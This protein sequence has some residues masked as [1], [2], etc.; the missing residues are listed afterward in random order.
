MRK[1]TVKI[2][3]KQLP[4]NS[5]IKKLCHHSLC[6][7]LFNSL[8]SV[9]TELYQSI[10]HSFWAQPTFMLI[11]FQ[12]ANFRNNDLLSSL[13][14]CICGQILED[15]YRF[16]SVCF[17]RRKVKSNHQWMP[18]VFTDIESLT[19]RWVLN[20]TLTKTTYLHCFANLLIKLLTRFEYCVSF[21]C[22]QLVAMLQ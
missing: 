22:N 10:V 16:Y 12:K 7:S 11:G 19:D 14:K 4:M 6:A 2:S 17:V 5:L 18:F 3:V 9:C 8:W 21:C 13:S 1:E 15:N 20:N